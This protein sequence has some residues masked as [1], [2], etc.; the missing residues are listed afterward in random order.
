MRSLFFLYFFDL[1]LILTEPEG[2]VYIL[3]A[4]YAAFYPLLVHS[5]AKYIFFLILLIS[6]VNVFL[7][8]CQSSSPL[9]MHTLSFM[10]NVVSF[11]S[12]TSCP[13]LK[14][15]QSINKPSHSWLFWNLMISVSAILSLHVD[16]ILLGTS[17]IITP[18]HSPLYGK[19][20]YFSGSHS[21]I[22]AI[23]FQR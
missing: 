7:S 11:P 16:L 6:C 1:F 12:S 19:H 21:S 13:I 8:F 9:F 17:A 4:L 2:R 23:Q 18:N 22:H 10:E 3:L 15:V 5:E 14:I 20:V